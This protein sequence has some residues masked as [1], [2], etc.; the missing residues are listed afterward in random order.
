MPR[1]IELKA[2]YPEL[3]RA[4][5]IARTLGAECVAIE[6]QRDTYF[7]AANGRL[8]LRHRRVAVAADTDA[9]RPITVEASELIHYHRPNDTEQRA[10]DY[11][12]VEVTDGDALREALSNAVGVTVEVRKKRTIYLHDGVRIHLDEVDGLGSFLEFEALVNERTDD[13]A[14]HAKLERLRAT[15]EIDAASIIAESY[16]DLSTEV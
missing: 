12:R 6:R 8:K 5:R 1:N 15:F 2:R 4:A 16:C 13:A 7:D 10:S 14:A 11:Q 3:Q 9:D